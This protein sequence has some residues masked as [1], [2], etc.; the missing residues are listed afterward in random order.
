MVTSIILAAGEGT[1]MKSNR[2]KVLH[3]ILNKPMI[4]YIMKASEESGADKT[5][6]IVGKNKENVVEA[7]N[8]PSLCYIEQPIGEGH[9]YGTGYAVKLASDE[10]A[11]EDDVLILNGDIPLLRGETLAG[12]LKEHRERNSVAT[13]LTSFIDDTRGYGHIVKDP[14]GFLERIVE[15]RDATEEEKKIKEFNPGIYLFRGSLLKSALEK[16]DTDND[17][18]EM[19]ITDVISILNREGHQVLA[20]PIEDVTEVYGINSKDQLSTAEEAMR[21]RVNEEYMKNG[22][23]M[24]NPA[25]I[26]IEPGVVIGRDTMIYANA[27]LLGKTVIG[28]DCVINGGSAIIDSVLK[29]R[30][31]IDRSV[32]EESTID[33]DTKVGPFAHLRPHSSLGKKVKIGN[34]V[35]VKNSVVGDETKSGH[36]AYIGDADL[37]KDINIGCGVIFVNYDGKNKHRTTVKDGAFIGSNANL[38]APITVQEEGFVAA[39][40]TITKDVDKGALAIERAEQKS[41]ANWVYTKKQ[42]KK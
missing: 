41:I 29:D 2:S 37:G 11:D 6:L 18:G 42:N 40:S 21:K 7:L 16:L 3:K 22:V 30:V 8:N 10:I 14:N 17:Q 35:E 31:C 34:F 20:Y 23:L 28:E 5:V 9:P 32:I 25:T 1:R 26:L 12:L 38:V 24:E 4:E 19:Y 39:G 13:I 15:D 27:Q 36:L 33:C